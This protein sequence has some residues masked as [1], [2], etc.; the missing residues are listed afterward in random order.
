MTSP[1][2]NQVAL[3]PGVAC[4]GGRR[5]VGR[6]TVGVFDDPLE[7][8]RGLTTDDHRWMRS[9]GR[10]GKQRT[11]PERKPTRAVQI[12][13][14]GQTGEPE[15]AMEWNRPRRTRHRTSASAPI[16][17]AKITI[18]IRPGPTSRTRTSITSAVRP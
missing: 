13:R 3:R 7:H 2:A 14:R 16:D 5:P 6:P 1:R 9:L 18:Q 10:L 11:D 4:L 17:P 15:G 8:V 12:E